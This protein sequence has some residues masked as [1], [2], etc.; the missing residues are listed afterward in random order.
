MKGIVLAGGTGSRLWPVTKGV[1]K[2]LVPVYDKP[3]IFYPISTLMMAGIRDIIV[4]TTPEDQTSFQRLLG[5]GSSFGI[6]IKYEVQPSPDGLA[7]AF[8]IAEKHIEGRKCALV[9]G[10]N[11]F[12]GPGLGSQLTQFAQIE[13][14]QIFAYRV[15]DPERYGVVEFGGDG[16][17]ISI[18]EK[19]VHPKSSY[20]IPGLYFYDENI[21]EIARAVKPSARGELEISSVNQTYLERGNLHVSILPR[22]TAWLDT[23][24]FTSLHDASSYVRALEERQ[25]TK[26]SCLEE[27]AFRH[28]WISKSELLDLA[29][30]YKSSPYGAYLYM[31]ANEE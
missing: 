31:V 3:L 1:S 6:N 10:D 24:T 30:A 25:G 16:K 18:E 2:Q 7:Q 5:D 26:I 4:I 15:S 12:Y 23:G 21:L 19:P 11:L 20:A 13:G 8:L 28:G 17:A 14:A 27:I 22:G 29:A 9:L